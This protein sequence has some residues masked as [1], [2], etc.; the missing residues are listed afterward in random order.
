[1][2]RES[3]AWRGKLR[4]G[5]VPALVLAAVCGVWVVLSQVPVWPGPR[6]PVFLG[7]DGLLAFLEDRTI[8]ARFA[9]RGEI[10]SPLKVCYVDVDADAMQALGNFP[11]NRAIFAETMDALFDRGGIRG[12]GFDFVFSSTGLPNLGREEAEKG[13]LALG[14]SV[15]RHGAVVLAA[16]YSSGQRLLGKSGGFLSLFDPRTTLHEADLPELP[17]FPVVGPTWGRVGLIDVVGDDVRYVPFFAPTQ[18]QTYLAMSLQLALIHYG[19]PPSAVEIGEQSIMLRGNDGDV[20][21]RIPLLLRQFVEPNW[22]SSWYSEQN[23]RASVISVL[24]HARLAEE[25]TG[26]EK[27]QAEEFFRAFKDAIV[28]VGPTD[29]M[30][31]DMAPAPLNEGRPVPR[32][33]LHGNMLK[34]IVG[35][36]FIAR[37]PRWVN[38]LLITGLGLGV[39]GLS[40]VPPRFVRGGK[41]LAV[42]ATVLYAA[43]AFGLFVWMNL[44]IPLVAPLG[45]ALV[46]TLYAVVSRL[47]VEEVRRRKIKMLF[48]SY[49]SSSVVEEIVESDEMPKTGGAEVEITAFFSDIASFSSLSEKLQPTELVTLMCDYLG[50][51]T[52][53]IIAAGGTLDKYVGDAIIA[54]FGAPLRQDDHAAAA[55]RAAL[56]LQEAQE[57][58]CRQW[59]GTPDAWPPEALRMSTRVGLNTGLAVVGNVGSELRFNYTMMG[60]TVNMAQR[61]EAAVA[62]FGTKILVTEATMEA[63]KKHDETL[64]F[65]ALDRILVAGNSE[66][67]EVCDLLAHG[68]EAVKAGAVRVAAYASARELY[69]AARWT[70]AREA[71]MAAAQHEPFPDRKNP[72]VVMAARCGVFASSGLTE[73]PAFPVSKG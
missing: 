54:M 71:F 64:V 10:P 2:E 46:C 11:W 60:G 47:S 53:A 13:S 31:K 27:A 21:A 9:M 55:C 7:P 17:D 33:S 66:P 49:V 23:P 28:L 59:G 69:L 72:C 42:L 56:A 14:R 12:I 45:A 15:R 34:T 16:N 57:R 51:G 38:V 8:D 65:R 20:V 39:A 30:L 43:A 40:V 6:G 48:G 61:M 32:V 18:N 35:D 62:H 22:F 52:A 24:E 19:L 4:R 73:S 41:L 37:P 63:A 26:E 44:L 50:E 29:P 68:E 25:G 36:R 1:M 70:E 58:L 5:A 3:G 67:V